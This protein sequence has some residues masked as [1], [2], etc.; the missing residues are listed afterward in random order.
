MFFDRLNSQGTN[1][2]DVKQALNYIM[3]S[4]NPTFTNLDREF[5]EILMNV[6]K[7][8]PL[9]QEKYFRIFSK[10]TGVKCKR[11]EGI[12]ANQFIIDYFGEIYP[13]WRWYEK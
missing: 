6:L 3:H 7:L 4:D 9:M 11:T 12:K 5:A 13:P 1:G 2:W 10:G 8:H